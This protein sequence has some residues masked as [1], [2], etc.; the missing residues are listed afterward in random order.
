[1]SRTRGEPA[2]KLACWRI[3]ESAGRSNHDGHLAWHIALVGLR[4]AL[5]G[6]DGALQPPV[7]AVVAS[8]EGRLADDVHAGGCGGFV[9]SAA[10]G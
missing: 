7:K 5:L 2:T 4:P 8:G 6:V 3:G 9:L 10:I 1:V